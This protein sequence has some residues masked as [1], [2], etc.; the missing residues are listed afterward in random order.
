MARDI[1][2]AI[3]YRCS[4][5]TDSVSPAVFDIG[6]QTYWGH[7]LDQ[8]SRSHVVND[9]VTVD[10][11]YAISHWRSIGTE[12]LSPT[13]FEIFGPKHVNERVNE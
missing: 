10:S 12:P 7:D 6:P 9:H 11:P 4:I 2:G 1:P 3:S 8:V 5:V 13:V